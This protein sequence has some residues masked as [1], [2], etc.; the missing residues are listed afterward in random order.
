MLTDGCV[1]DPESVCQLAAEHSDTIRVFTFGLGSGCDKNLVIGAARAG[2]GTHTIVED[3]SADLNG[4]VIRALSNAME[5]SLKGASHGWM[6]KANDQAQELY[7]NS[8][9]TST[10][11]FSAS[12]FESVSFFFRTEEDPV[13]KQK[14]D[15]TFGKVDF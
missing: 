9:L 13:T 4:Q 12:E 15:L 6:G 7:R 1:G 8:L 11:V 2:R 5:P 14:I 3:G 10:K